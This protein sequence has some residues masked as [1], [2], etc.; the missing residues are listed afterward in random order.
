MNKLY[1][2]EVLKLNN[3][4]FPEGYI[5]EDTSFYIKAIPYIK[6]TE[7]IDK[8][9]VYHF[10]RDNSTMNSKREERVGNIFPV[11]QDILDEYRNKEM[12]EEYHKYLEYFCVKIL[13]CS[14]LKRIA[15]LKDKALKKKFIKKT[16]QMISTEFPDYRKND[17]FRK[18]MIG[19]Y[20][21]CVNRISINIAAFAFRSN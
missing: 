9:Y 20:M 5:Y 8:E 4:L 6:T 13:L 2:A 18:N 7:F 1:K 17:L 21:R 14:S 19:L 15:K 12:Y 16:I 11:L 10:L 3:I